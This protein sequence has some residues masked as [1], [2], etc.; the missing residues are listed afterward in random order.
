[1][2]RRFG[3]GGHDVG[4]QVHQRNVKSAAAVSSS[5]QGASSAAAAAGA[6]LQ[7]QG[8]SSAAAAT[9]AASQQAATRK[10]TRSGDE[11]TRSGDAEVASEEGL[12][13][14]LDDEEEN[15]GDDA[16]GM[17]GCHGVFLCGRIFVRC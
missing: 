11:R 12:D 13:D 10:R 16:R 3:I 4:H 6:A 5:S 15:V 7:Q 17:Y 1:M 2:M 9:G 14:E 8:A